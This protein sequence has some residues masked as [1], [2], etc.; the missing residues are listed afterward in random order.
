MTLDGS[1]TPKAVPEEAVIDATRF[2]PR[3]ASK[4]LQAFVERWAGTTR[5][6]QLN[7]FARDQ[8]IPTD[9]LDRVMTALIGCGLIQNTGPNLSLAVSTSDADRYATVLRGVAYEQ[10][11]HRD[12]NYVELTVSL[13]AHPSRLMEALPKQGFSWVGLYDTEDNLFELASRALSRFTI[14]SP[15]VD[16]KGIAWILEL[17]EA[18]LPR[19]V[20]RTL[21]VRGRNPAELE[22]RSSSAPA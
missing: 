4:L 22:F 13:P 8:K 7:D 21:I 18:T 16:G 1:P 9:R 19:D 17:F 2:D 10:Y 12:T 15:F 20:G 6:A 14:L 5:R 11:C 3:N